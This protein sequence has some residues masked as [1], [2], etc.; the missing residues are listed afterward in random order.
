[1]LV[2]RSSRSSRCRSTLTA[3]NRNAALLLLTLRLTDDEIAGWPGICRGNV[4]WALCKSGCSSLSSL[5]E[6]GRFNG[7]SGKISAQMV[8]LD[9]RRLGKSV[10]FRRKKGWTQQVP[11]RHPGWESLHVC[12]DDASGAA[13]THG[14]GLPTCCLYGR[15]VTNFF[16]APSAFLGG[17][18]L[19]QN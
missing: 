3:H 7:V 17:N 5:E 10:G 6:K 2:N 18:L 19:L 11:R 4:F 9:I 13:S 15:L 8:H 16:P 14:K 1:M 12:I